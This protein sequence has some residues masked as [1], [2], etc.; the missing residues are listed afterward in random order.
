MGVGKIHKELLGL[1]IDKL[2][3]YKVS[4]MKKGLAII[5]LFL[6]LA[7]PIVV[8]QTSKI[9][10]LY[11][12]VYKNDTVELRDFKI[13]E[14]KQDV[15]IQ[16]ES[17]Y[18]LKIISINNR[19]L[20]QAPLQISFYAFPQQEGIDQPSIIQTDEATLYLRLPYFLDASKIEIYHK[21]K[22]IF[23]HQI[24]GVTA[25]GNGICDTELGETYASCP[26]DCPKKEQPNYWM[27]A[28]ALV[29]II[30]IIGYLIYRIKF[31]K[32]TQ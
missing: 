9:F 27:Y 10:V 13:S 8:A 29:I 21:N 24:P 1:L 5:I 6:L 3:N 30:S 12:T 23:Q 25:C 16:Q 14:G 20:F 15:F 17:E 32:V 26:Q 19:I 22:L 31:V 7:A 4:V 18:S 11:A 28:I 2:K